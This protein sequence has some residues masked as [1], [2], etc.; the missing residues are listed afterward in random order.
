M[1]STVIQF[2]AAAALAFVPAVAG[3]APL[4]AA[5]ALPKQSV[6]VAG[7]ARR[8]ATPSKDGSDLLGFP[9]LGLAGLVAVVVVVA[10]VAS[11]GGGRSPG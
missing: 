1:R 2:A 6:A 10:V 9:L 4:R 8:A 3:A 11:S 5:T 7:A